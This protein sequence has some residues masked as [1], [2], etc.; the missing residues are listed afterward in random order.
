[1]SFLFY[2]LETFG[3]NPQW[4]RIAQFAAIRTDDELQDTGETYDL[5]IRPA[6]DRLP[7]PMACAITRTSPWQHW[8]RGI[9]E[10]E[11]AL[12]IA[13]AMSVA[14]T[15]TLGHNSYGFDDGMVRNLLYRNFLPIY[16][17]EWRHG[18]SRFDTLNALRAAYALRPDGINWP[19]N[20]DGNVYFRLEALAEANDVREG[21][22]HE[23]LSDVRAT[24]GM[25]RLLRKNQ[26]R[27][28]DY[29]LSLRNKHEVRQ[30]LDSGT[31]QILLG[32]Q[33]QFGLR[34]FSSAPLLPLFADESDPNKFY[35]LNLLEDPSDLQAWIQAP[36]DLPWPRM[37]RR[38]SINEAPPLFALRHLRDGEL[39]RLGWDRN[40]IS[41][42]AE[43]LGAT[44]D[45]DAL[46][47]ALRATRREY[48]PA[49]DVDGAMFEGFFSG[50]A[51]AFRRKVRSTPPDQLAA[52][53]DEASVDPRL[54]TLLLRYRAQNYP[55]SLN[56]AERA[57]WLSH[58]RKN[59]LE[60][61]SPVG[62]VKFLE[63]LA[64][65]RAQFAEDAEVLRVLDET[66]S[67]A[68]MLLERVSGV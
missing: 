58:C 5:L 27:F 14:N 9:P 29:L 26:P 17:R 50:A 33:A 28:W 13:D 49:D 22:A 2:D 66:E 32:I 65:A 56:A 34:N 64:E 31:P 59:L 8:Q 68:N 47:A 42:N 23:A 24:I 12:V 3:T 16:D 40:A 39:E 1:M 48:A 18:N 57:E 51:D 7:S 54:P 6:T 67:F 19:T 30:L 61:D 63:E 36:Q 55:D 21:D 41:A 4:H 43:Q 10:A 46:H 44:L 62:H 60:P 53:Q 25:A 38:L 35:A 20:A 37:L 11:A 15:C 45:L 52:L